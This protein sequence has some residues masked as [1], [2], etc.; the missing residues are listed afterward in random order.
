MITEQRTGRISGR[1]P[2]ARA[3]QRV[4]LECLIADTTPGGAQL[5]PPVERDLDVM[6]Q[7]ERDGL[8]HWGRNGW[9]PSEAGVTWIAELARAET[10]AVQ[11]LRD[12]DD[13]ELLDYLRRLSAAQ[14][15]VTDPDTFEAVQGDLD[16]ARAERA[17]REALAE[18]AGGRHQRTEVL[19]R[20]DDD[21]GPATEPITAQPI[22]DPDRYDNPEW[23]GDLRAQ[24]AA[25][26]GLLRW[27]KRRLTIG[28][29]FALGASTG[30]L[31]TV[32]SAW[33]VLG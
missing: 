9:E 21:A 10:I 26:R 6:A 1:L 2:S 20:V 8:A 14:A 22:D 7:L 3:Q 24:I 27:V 25:E 4:Q 12:L 28:R 29:A 32:G 15:K 33:A 19:P 13:A 16:R 17:R 11:Q 23:G 31:V 18:D 30:V 5:R